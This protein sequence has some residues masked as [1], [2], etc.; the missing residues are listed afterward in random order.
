MR[1]EIDKGNDNTITIRQ[2]DIRIG[3]GVYTV[4]EINVREDVGEYHLA[5]ATMRLNIDEEERLRQ[6]LN[7]RHQ[8]RLQQEG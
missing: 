1:F 8:A 6:Y 4:L 2:D 7:D 3:I 5:D